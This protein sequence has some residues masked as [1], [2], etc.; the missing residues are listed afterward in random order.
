MSIAML[1]ANVVDAKSQFTFQH[2]QK[3]AEL[4]QHLAKEL[5]LNVEMQKALYLTGLVHDI[6]KLHTQKRSCIN[7]VNSMRASIFVFN[8]IRPILVIPCKWCLANLWCVSGQE[9]TMSV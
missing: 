5:G 4:C 2:S 3:V 7:P 1:M 9:T 6:G 8:A